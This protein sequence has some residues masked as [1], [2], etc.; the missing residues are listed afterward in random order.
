MTSALER[1]VTRQQPDA[2]PP[3]ARSRGSRLVSALTTTLCVLA[4]L[5]ALFIVVGPMFLPY[6]LTTT[7]TGSMEPTVPQGSLVVD[8]TVPASSLQV[9]QI[10]TFNVPGEHRT[11]THRLHAVVQQG[12]TVYFRTKGD[13]NTL[14]DAWRIQATGN[15]YRVWFH[16]PYVGRITE[17]T[18]S[19]RAASAAAAIVVVLV[20]G[21]AFARQTL[22]SRRTT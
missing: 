15:G 2:S 20:V 6:R 17:I 7:S 18:R 10:I 4:L 19:L 14:P 1:S 12:G 5:L 22:P 16:I 11:V 13:A 21:T 8:H 9:G 3:P